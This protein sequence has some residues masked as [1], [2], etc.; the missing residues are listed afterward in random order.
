MIFKVT[1]ATINE[2]AMIPVIRYIA[3]SPLKEFGVKDEDVDRVSIIITEGCS[4]VCKYAYK[5]A[6]NYRIDLEYYAAKMVITITDHGCGFDL[7]IIK[8]VSSGQVGGY[9]L[10]LIREYSDKLDI[11]S[12]KH[13]GTKIYPEVM[14]HYQNNRHSEQADILDIDTLETG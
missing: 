3:I 14:L 5:G 4:N 9:G 2:G 12:M 1:L 13:Q 11:T 6:D 10:S 8:A 7:M